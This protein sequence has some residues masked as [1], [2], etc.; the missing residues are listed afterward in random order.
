MVELVDDGYTLDDNLSMEAAHGHSPGHM[1]IRAKDAGKTGIFC[2]DVIHNVLQVRYPDV[3]SMT[4][5]DPAQAAA[6]R[7]RVLSECADHG[8]LLLPAHLGKPHFG[9]ISRAHNAFRF[10]PGQY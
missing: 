1:L 7:H 2:G 8:H 6:T 3:N 9:R 4:C 10:H 5:E